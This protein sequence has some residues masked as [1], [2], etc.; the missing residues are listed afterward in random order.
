[1]LNVLNGSEAEFCRSVAMSAPR[2]R[3]IMNTGGWAVYGGTAPW[4]T[5]SL[6]KI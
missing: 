2:I 5:L 3:R 6:V 4:M 1:M